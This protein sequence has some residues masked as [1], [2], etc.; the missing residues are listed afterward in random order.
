MKLL[1]VNTKTFIKK[2]MARSHQNLKSLKLAAPVNVP[3]L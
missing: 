1:A 2:I 3:P